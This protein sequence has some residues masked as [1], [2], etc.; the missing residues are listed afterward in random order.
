MAKVLSEE[1]AKITLIRKNGQTALNI[2]LAPEIEALFKAAVNGE[3]V[4]V[5][6]KNLD[7]YW[8]PVTRITNKFSRWAKRGLLN[9]PDVGL[10][11]EKTF[12][13]SPIFAVGT[14]SENGVTLVYEDLYSRELIEEYAKQLK[15]VIHEMYNEYISDVTLEHSMT[16]KM[17]AV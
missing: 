17:V 10:D 4:K 15:T 13:F 3:K 12:N 7:Y 11:V 2:H 14:G 8:Y 9:N 6:T 5:Q 16:M 1:I